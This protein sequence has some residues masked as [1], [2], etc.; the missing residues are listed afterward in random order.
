MDVATLNALL[1]RMLDTLKADTALAAMVK[2][3]DGTFRLGQLGAVDETV[4]TLPL[5]YVAAAPTFIHDRRTIGGPPAP[6]VS[7]AEAVTYVI[8]AVAVTRPEGSPFAAQT[9]A[10]AFGEAIIGALSRNL[11]LHDGTG[12][13]PLAHNI[14]MD[15]VERYGPGMGTDKEAVTVLCHV[16]TVVEHMDERNPLYSP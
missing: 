5:V 8:H 7:P 9:R 10:Y 3:R 15:M 13:D 2:A 16:L 14:Q 11:V 1:E 12:A 6:G 4:D